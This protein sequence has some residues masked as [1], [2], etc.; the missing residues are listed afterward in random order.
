M[1]LSPP[2]SL[3]VTPTTSWPSLGSSAAATDEST[4]PLIATITFMLTRTLPTVALRARNVEIGADED[5]DGARRRRRRWSSGRASSAARHRPARSTPIAASTCDGSIAPLAQADAADAQ[6]PASSSRK[7]SASLSTPST[8]T[9]A[10]PATLRRADGLADPGDGLD[11]A[12]D[13][14]VAQRGDPRALGDPLGVGRR[15]A[16]AIATIAGHV[17]RPAAAVALLAAADE[18]RLDRHTLAD[19]ERPDAL[20][21]AELVGLSDIRSTCG[22]SWRRS[23]QHAACTASVCS[24]AVGRI[25]RATRRD[26][27]EVVDRADLVVDRHRPT[28]STRRRRDAAASWSQIDT[29]PYR[30]RR[31]PARDDARPAWRTAWCSAAGHT[32]RHR[33]ARRTRD[34]RVVALGAAAREH[35][36]AGAAAE[37][38]G[39][40][41]PGL[42]DRAAAPRRAK[43]WEPLGLAKPR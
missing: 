24:N 18:Q 29:H 33:D 25:P 14:P 12:A 27:G 35:H 43:R 20:G 9:C 31:R 28:R 1:S 41:V 36:L 8:Q 30:R 26:V 37:D 23:S 16:A 39:D 32:G 22:H 17:V 15:S 38:V 3:I 40:L 21:P 5:L 2:H 4:P 13:Q 10:D 11:E 19:D 34:R 42:V 6:T 7:S